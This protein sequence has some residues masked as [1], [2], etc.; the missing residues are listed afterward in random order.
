MAVLDKDWQSNENKQRNEN[1]ILPHFSF[2]LSRS[3]AIAK[4]QEKIAKSELP[5]TL[6]FLY[7]GNVSKPLIG[8]R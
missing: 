2:S 4:D 1:C 7:T 5:V 3:E 8:N 6:V